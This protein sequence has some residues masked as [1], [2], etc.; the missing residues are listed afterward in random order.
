MKQGKPQKSLSLLDAVDMAS[1][2]SLEDELQE[3][4]LKDLPG[5]SISFLFEKGAQAKVDGEEG[6]EDDGEGGG[7]GDGEGGEG[8]EADDDEGAE[9]EGS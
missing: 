7:Q 6:E 9:S 2:L 8:G 1:E 3:M 5:G 4:S